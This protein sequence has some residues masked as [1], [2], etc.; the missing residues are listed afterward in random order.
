ME[1]RVF[2]EEGGESGQMELAGSHRDLSQ[3]GCHRNDGT[4]SRGKPC[5]EI[6]WLFTR[7]QSG[8]SLVAHAILD[9]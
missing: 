2:E 3:L 1:A 4:T 8:E 6:I 7:R 5:L 9:L